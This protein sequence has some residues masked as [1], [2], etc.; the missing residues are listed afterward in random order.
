MRQ[1]NPGDTQSPLVD[2]PTETVD[3]CL[4]CGGERRQPLFWGHDD[5]YGCPGSY[6]VVECLGCGLAYL[7]IRPQ[8]SVLAHIYQTYYSPQ[9]KKTGGSCLGSFKQRIKK[10]IIGRFYWELVNPPDNLYRT[11]QLKPGM[12]VL[13]V[14]SGLPVAEVPRFVQAGGAWVG[15][16]IDECICRALEA[17]G[18]VAYCG[19]LA[20]FSQTNPNPFDCMVLSQ[21]IEHIYNPRE[22]MRLARDLLKP[23]GMIV[24]SCPNYDSFLRR[25]CKERWLHWHVPYHVAQFNRRTLALLAEAS[26]LRLTRFRTVTPSNWYAAAVQLGRGLP[27]QEGWLRAKNRLN[28]RLLDK[29]L[30]SLHNSDLGDALVANLERVL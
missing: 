7:A 14:G 24:L 26:G 22:F 5:R 2:I 3:A 25:H 17:K 13:D 11:F 21:V 20:D 4:V 23:G 16:E 1:N 9:L 15:V 28:Q 10:S 27:Y 30:A 19:T 18:L 12:R 6:P 29:R 8:A